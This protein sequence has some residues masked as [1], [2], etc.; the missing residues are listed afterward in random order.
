MFPNSQSSRKADSSPS[1]LS[2]FGGE[3]RIGISPAF[4]SFCLQLGMTSAFLTSR[5]ISS[6]S[7]L[8]QHRL[9]P[10]HRGAPKWV[11]GS[12]GRQERGTEKSGLV[13]GAKQRARG[14]GK[15]VSPGPPPASAYLPSPAPRNP[16]TLRVGRQVLR[17]SNV[18][19]VFHY[20]RSTIRQLCK[21]IINVSVFLEIFLLPARGKQR[22]CFP[23]ASLLLYIL[24]NC[25]PAPAPRGICIIHKCLRDAVTYILPLP[26]LEIVF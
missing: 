24:I 16:S 18:S 15:A 6:G 11:A 21:E 13:S 10:A 4:P 1:R 25:A 19:N 3:H 22:H 5:V 2:C 12:C 26:R 20:N 7:S 23:R 8:L 9:V 17:A 14:K